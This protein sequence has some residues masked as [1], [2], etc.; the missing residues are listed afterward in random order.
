MRKQLFLN[1]AQD[2]QTPLYEDV[3]KNRPVRRLLCLDSHP[4]LC[5]LY[6]TL[7]KSVGYSVI[8]TNDEQEALR[9]MRRQMVD[10]FTHDIIRNGVGGVNFIRLMKSDELL[11]YMPILVISAMPRE[12]VGYQLW[13][14]GLDLESDVDGFIQKPFKVEALLNE[15]GAIVQST[16]K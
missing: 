9:I 7:F 12:F 15:L 14:D 16:F 5:R 3:L 1:S 4:S 6:K 8:T 13:L 11:R 2:D 10:V